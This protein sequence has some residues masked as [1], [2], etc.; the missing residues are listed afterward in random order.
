MHNHI[1]KW[2]DVERAIFCADANCSY[3]LDAEQI[4]SIVKGTHP[5]ETPVTVCPECAGTGKRRYSVFGTLQDCHRC[6]GKKTND[7]PKHS[8]ARTRG[9]SR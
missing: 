9:Q 8:R 7:L 3:S 5:V 6:G 4:L 1:L 2:S